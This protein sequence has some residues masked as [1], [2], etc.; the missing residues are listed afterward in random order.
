M[1]NK[2]AFEL[3][4]KLNRRRVTC[5][6]KANIHKF[7][8]GMFLNTFYEIS[9]DYK[10]LVSDDI[11]VDN[12]CM[13][14]VKNPEDFDVL[15]LPN[16][17]GDIVSDLCAGLVGSLGLAY[18]GNIGLNYAVFEAVHGSAP[19]IANKNIANPSAIILAA[20]YMLKYLNLFD[21]AYLIEQALFKNFENGIFT[22]DLKGNYSTSEFTQH[23]IKNISTYKQVSLNNEN[24][25]IEID[26][27]KNQIEIKD[28]P[29][30]RDS[31]DWELFGVYVFIEWNDLRTL[32]AIPFEYKSSVS[33]THLTLPTNREV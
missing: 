1:V 18:S 7:S 32:P 21:F 8:D 19:D 9:K 20:T 25:K 17:F 4:K 22:K 10:D 23:L 13:Q 14:L 31:K 24:N 26:D 29:V 11:I 12:L 6:H 15:V 28:I 27:N 5:V 3:A 30:L 2:F 33:Y 16:I